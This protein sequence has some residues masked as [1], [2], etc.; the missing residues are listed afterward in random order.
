MIA[1]LPWLPAF[2]AFDPIV[3]AKL[4]S[5]RYATVRNEEWIEDQ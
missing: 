4:R 3:R 2:D 5:K 1:T